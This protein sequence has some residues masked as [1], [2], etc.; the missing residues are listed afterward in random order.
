TYDV[1]LEIA[2]LAGS[3]QTERTGFIT[4]IDGIPRASLAANETAGIAPLSVQFTD[5]S[6]GEGIAERTW[7]FGDGTITTAT[8]PFERT[9][10]HTYAAAGEYTVTLA[11]ASPYGTDVATRYDYIT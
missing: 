1:S 6:T 8:G 7:N 5:T 10:V 2:T 11:V 9:I 4:V 3:D